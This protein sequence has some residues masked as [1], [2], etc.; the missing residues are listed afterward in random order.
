MTTTAERND[1]SCTADDCTL[2]DALNLANAVADANMINFAPGLT[3][4]MGTAR[5]LHL[6]GWRSLTQ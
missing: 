2:V 6:A 1:G 5:S 3:G 4:A